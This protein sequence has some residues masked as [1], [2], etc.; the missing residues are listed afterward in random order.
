MELL[1]PAGTLEVFETAVECGAD[2]IYIGAPAANA[3]AL[4]KHFT[5]E[6]C[7]AMA[8]YAHSHDVK[9]YVAMNSLLKDSEIPDVIRLLAFFTEIKVDA[10]I[11]QDLGLLFLAQRYFPDLPLHASTLLGANNS[12]AVRQ[13]AEM[14]FERVVVAREMLLSE[15]E[16]AAKN[17]PVELE[18]FVHGAMCFSYSGLCMFSSFLGGKSGL[19]GRCSQPCRRRYTWENN[20]KGK[21]AGYLFSMNDLQGIGL[22]DRLRAAGITSLKIEGRMR[23]R[24]YVEQVVTAYRMVLDNPADTKSM[25]EAENMLDTAMGRK[26]SSGYFNLQNHAELISAQHS[27]NIGMF[28]G[29]A[30]STDLQGRTGIKLLKA[31]SIGD[32][33]RIHLEKSGERA[34]FTNN[35]MWQDNSSLDKAS[36]GDHVHIRLPDGVVA[37]DSI[38]KVDSRESRAKAVRRLTIRPEKFKQ[39][40]RHIRNVP[41]INDLCNHLCPAGKKIPSRHLKPRHKSAGLRRGKK[42]APRAVVP[43]TWWLKIDDL[44]MLRK[45]PANISPDRTVIILTPK[46]IQQF[47][48]QSIPGNQRRGLIWALPPI[49]LEE[50]IPFYYEA[51]IDLALHDF[52]DWQIG[53]ISQIQLFRAATS[54]I[55]AGSRTQR[56]QSRKKVVKTHR[57]KEFRLF[58]HYSLNVM[59]RF[60]LRSLTMLGIRMPQISLEADREMVAELGTIQKDHA[61][62]MTVYGYPPLFSARPNPDFFTYDK[63]FVSPRGEKFVLRQSGNTTL[64]LPTAPFSLLPILRELKDFGINYVVVDL[65]GA[66]IGKKEFGQLWGQLTGSHRPAKLSSFNY[67]GKLQ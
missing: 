16:A 53:H 39:L 50:E 6:E 43:I 14:G 15:I 23:N 58:G 20:S 48:R 61:A 25:A 56:K 42:L 28:I 18:A 27:G 19:R 9:L 1:A 24:Q 52:T 62:G 41:K 11:I 35:E 47:R 5:L 22:V 30:E 54:E 65:S 21:A 59:N 31:L 3:R 4:A 13:F 49:I 32:R 17:S 60:A 46:T 51:I 55:M 36:G 29:K 12:I 45:L 7:A 66:R 44:N 40:V 26:T 57:P 67:R 33:L 2:A 10:L 34:S 38:Y 63:P 64:A 8:D 37:G